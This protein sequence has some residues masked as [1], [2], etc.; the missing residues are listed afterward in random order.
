MFSLIDSGLYIDLTPLPNATS[1]ANVTRATKKVSLA[2]LA[3]VD[4]VC[5][6]I[7]PG[8]RQPLPVRRV[9]DRQR[10]AAACIWCTF[11]FD[12]YQLCVDLRLPP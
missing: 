11:Q 10:H 12:A 5:A 7:F 1:G 8:D 3:A 6:S 9:C 2:A 4:P